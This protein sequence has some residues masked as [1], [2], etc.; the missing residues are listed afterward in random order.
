LSKKI[1]W[2]SD[3]WFLPTGY[4]QVSRNLLSR[5]FKSGFDVHNLAFQNV[6]FNTDLVV[7][8][9]MISSYKM[10]HSLH[11]NESYGNH[12]SVE[13]YNE[14]I[15]PDI[16][17][18]LCDSFMIKWLCDKRPD[19]D[20]I[21]TRA[22]KLHGKKLF[23]FPFDSKDVYDGAE[24]L[25]R[26][27]DIRVAMA[28]W[29]RDTL[30]KG[31]G[32]DSHYI[33]HGVDTNIYRPLPKE[34]IN[35]VRKSNG[36]DEDTFVV[37]SVS[38]NQ[39]RKNIPVLFKAFAD[40]AENK[41]DTKLLM[42][43]DPVDPQGTNLNDL[44]KQYGIIDKVS[45]GMKRFSLGVPEFTIN[46][47]YNTMDVHALSTT[48]EGFGLPI[49]ESMAA[50]TPNICTDYTTAEE[51]LGDGRGERVKLMGSFP[52][53]VGQLNTHRAL[54]DKDDMVKKFEKLYKNKK[55]R[56]QYSDRGRKFVLE[57]YN[58][59]KVVRMWN[60][61]LEFGTVYEKE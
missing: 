2:C 48:G 33:P 40:F 8:D 32:L 30:K 1:L 37:G 42:H 46:L 58:W 9:R 49:I 21:I 13:F 53:I 11:P 22:K 6:G 50:G 57:H 39:S 12:G 17:A 54:A 36:W 59:E 10:Y 47:A 24:N 29:S 56:K 61:L 28:K 45:Y 14:I 31:T 23:Y 60:E 26:E 55:L 51:L 38:R 5:L 43:C 34:M 15:K 7:S 16:T 41:D 52:Y 18:F 19:K 35:G 25:M 20:K 4:S 44:A 3:S 27:M